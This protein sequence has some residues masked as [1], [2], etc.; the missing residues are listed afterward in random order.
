MSIT[1]IEQAAAWIHD[2]D[3][4]IA[5]TGAGVS[6]P[7]GIPDFRS[8]GSGLWENAS[9]MKIASLT[10][11]R[12]NPQAF[13]EWVRPLVFA[14]R[15]AKPNAAHRALV[16]LEKASKLSAVITQNT[17]SL[18]SRAGNTRVIELHGH[19]RTATCI[20]CF[21]NYD[22]EPL[23]DK[24]LEDGTITKCAKCGGTLKPDVILFEEQ[25]PYQAVQAAKQA[26]RSADLMI[27]IGTSLEVAPASD[28]PVLAQRNGAKVIIINREAPIMAR[29]DLMILG[30]CDTILPNIVRCL[31]TIPS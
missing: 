18:H 23:V 1:K 12:K 24:Y 6:T 16:D 19:M 11:F 30:E 4:V 15:N 20:Y 10:G 28:I 22:N 13:Y 7:S 26:A 25:L 17:D 2:A 3:T 8:A 31:D 29:A 9:P 5:F 14:K 21:T 27:V